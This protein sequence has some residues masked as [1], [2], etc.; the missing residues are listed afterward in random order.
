MG[1]ETNK[2]S[3]KPVVNEFVRSRNIEES[4][5]EIRL[6]KS[7]LLARKFPIAIALKSCI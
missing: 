7:N 2:G 1:A 5:Q 6:K 4:A 3:Y